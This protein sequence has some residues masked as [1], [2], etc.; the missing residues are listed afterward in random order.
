MEKQEYKSIFLSKTFWFAV[1]GL[2]GSLTGLSN[3]EIEDLSSQLLTFGV[4]IVSLI[5][6]AGVIVGRVTAK[7]SIKI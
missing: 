4:S 1:A 3:A 6:F 2:I 7:K 5:S